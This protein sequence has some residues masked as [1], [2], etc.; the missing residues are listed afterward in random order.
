MPVTQALLRV[1][2]QFG[3]HAN[4]LDPGILQFQTGR[5]S[6]DQSAAA[7]GT[8]DGFD[9]WQIL[10]NFQRDGALS[11][12]DLFVVVGRDDLVVV[13]LREF[14]RLGFAFVA[15]GTNKDD[16]GAVTS[17]SFD[18]DLWR[19]LGHHYDRFRSQFASGVRDA[20]CMISARVG[21]DSATALLIR[22]RCDLVEGTAD[23][24]GADRLEVL[25][26]EIQCATVERQRV[27][28]QRRARS[29]TLNPG[30][31]G[32]DVGETNDG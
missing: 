8:E 16:L 27:F 31:C 26:F 19:V 29:Y 15:A 18:L 2:G 4:H 24:E 23:L 6:A 22:Q 11:G 9:V 20:L 28:Q 12:D 25:R 14:F 3:L 10:Q 17:G 21:D 32:F 13:L 7:D 5:D 1:V 30:L